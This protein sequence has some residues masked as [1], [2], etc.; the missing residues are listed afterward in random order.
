MN[1]QLEIYKNQLVFQSHD[2]DVQMGVT[3]QDESV[4]LNLNQMAELFHRDKSVI[5][6]HIENVFTE[7]EL[8]EKATVAFF[9]TV[10]TEGKRTIKRNTEFFNLDMIISVG[11]RVNSKRGTEFR[12]WASQIFKQYLLEGYA[13]NQKHLQGTGLK[14]IT[15]ALDLL[16]RSLRVTGNISDIGEKVLEIIQQYA[17]SWHLLLAYDENRLLSPSL[18]SI[19]CKITLEEL[20]AAMGALKAQLMQQ[21]E[22]SPL[23]GQPGHESMEGIF[24]NIHQ[25][26]NDTLLYPSVI[27]RAAHLFYF[28]IKD[29]PF[30]DGNKRIA[31]FVLLLY[32]RQHDVKTDVLTNEAL[33]A[34][35]LLVAQSNPSDKEIILKLVLNL[36]SMD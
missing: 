8:E 24:G 25:T 11:Y 1:T 20:E 27:E 19:D 31:S 2:G 4:W 21:N 35:A 17:K 26:F 7:G 30:V 28:V 14:E 29:H 5:S 3:V 18:K 15:A 9:A 22:A 6:R 32:L 16:Q 10:Q 36:I 23:F 12:R 13:L 33:V 34:L